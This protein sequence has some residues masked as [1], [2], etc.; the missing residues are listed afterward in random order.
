[1]RNK[2][3][4]EF[5][6]D[7]DL[8]NTRLVAKVSQVIRADPKNM[9]SNLE[10][11][12][13]A[14]VDDGYGDEETAE[15]DAT[16]PQNALQKYLS[17]YFE[18]TIELGSEVLDAFTIEK[19]SDDPNYPLIRRYFKQGNLPLKRLLLFGLQIEPTNIDLLS[20]LAF[21]HEFRPLLQELKS[22]EFC[23]GLAS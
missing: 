12:G 5:D 9:A 20:D 23:S 2:P 7:E 10:K 14:W 17:A 11:L 19:N 4:D 1:M 18:G 8:E 21:L 15:E 22:P 3:D 6:S 16:T 13:F